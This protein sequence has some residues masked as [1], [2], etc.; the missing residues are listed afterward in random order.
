M[1]WFEESNTEVVEQFN[2]YDEYSKNKEHHAKLSHEIIGGAAAFE[3]AKAY[4]DHVAKNGKPD[5]H[6]KAK[7]FLAGAVGVFVEREF[8]TKGLDFFDK[9]EAKR[10]GEHRAERELERQY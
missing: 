1:G 5:S 4:E 8:E 3:A 2:Q 6:A 10:R 7:E 9:E